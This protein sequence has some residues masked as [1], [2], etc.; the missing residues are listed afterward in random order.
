MA[1]VALFFTRTIRHE[2]K[3]TKCSNMATVNPLLDFVCARNKGLTLL[4]LISRRPLQ[5]LLFHAR[6]MKLT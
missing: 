2:T 1:C 5:V 3:I 6:K 4:T